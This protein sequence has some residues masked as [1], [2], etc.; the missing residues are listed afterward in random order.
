[1]VQWVA[2]LLNDGVYWIMDQVKAWVRTFMPM[3]IGWVIVQLAAL[4]IEF[5]SDDVALIESAAT[6]VVAG[7][8]YAA[9]QLFSRWFPWVQKIFVFTTQPTYLRRDQVVVGKQYLESLEYQVRRIG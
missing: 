8:V 3:L 9:A 6:V 5:N 2:G 4:G 7:L 1:M